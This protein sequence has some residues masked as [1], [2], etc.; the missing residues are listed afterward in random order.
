[1]SSSKRGNEFDDRG[2]PS[3]QVKVEEGTTT[4]SGDQGAKQ[5]A[6]KAAEAAGEHPY[7]L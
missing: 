6:D 4:N 1:M 2:E 7:T 3:K 5:E